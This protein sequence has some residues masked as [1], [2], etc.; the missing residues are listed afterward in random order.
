[1]YLNDIEKEKY[2]FILLSLDKIGDKVSSMF[3]SLDENLFYK[4]ELFFNAI[5]FDKIYHSSEITSN[6]VTFIDDYLFG[7]NIFIINNNLFEHSTAKVYSY[8]VCYYEPIGY[9]ILIKDYRNDS[10]YSLRMDM[11]DFLSLN[12][13]NSDVIHCLF[14]YFRYRFDSEFN[15]Y[16]SI[17][18][19]INS[20]IGSYACIICNF[21]GCYISEEEYGMDFIWDKVE[22]S[23]GGNVYNYSCYKFKIVGFKRIRGRLILTINDVY[24]NYE[25]G[26]YGLKAYR[27]GLYSDELKDDKFIHVIILDNDK[28][29]GML[30]DSNN[31]AFFKFKKHILKVN[32]S[33]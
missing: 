6:D 7:I 3:D 12:L 13:F 14:E 27:K 24:Y 11:D 15:K 18:N 4:D 25:T 31:K 23:I 28:F 10:Y 22:S 19:K 17:Y 21:D 33:F 20:N 8:Y 9:D 32:K 5:G 1:M 16:G 29:I 30:R 26:L 2:D